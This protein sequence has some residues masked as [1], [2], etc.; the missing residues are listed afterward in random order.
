LIL[1]VQADDLEG[2]GV[3]L[4]DLE[5]LTQFLYI[6]LSLTHRLC[7]RVHRP[8]GLLG[9]FLDLIHAL[10][11]GYLWIVKK[12]VCFLHEYL[13]HR[14]FQAQSMIPQ[15]IEPFPGMLGLI[16]AV[17]SLDGA[18]VP[19]LDLVEEIFYCAGQEARVG[20][21]ASEGVRFP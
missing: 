13:D 4:R 19:L 2:L 18:S 17:F 16:Q 6:G 14:H 9:D 20:G 8:Y 5:L 15:A 21:S 3:E 10:L 11:V 1:K 12:V 7:E